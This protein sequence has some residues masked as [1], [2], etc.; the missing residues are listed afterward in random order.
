MTGVQTCALPISTGGD[1][2]AYAYHCMPRGVPE[3]MQ[4]VTRSY[5]FVLTPGLIAIIPQNNE[6]RWVYMDGRKMPADWKK[7]YNGFSIGHWEGEMLVVE[8][9]GIRPNTD[10]FYG[11]PGGT[12]QHVLE[13][14]KRIGNET[15]QYDTTIEDPTALASPY[16]FRR[17]FTRSPTPISD[18][19]CLQNNRDVGPDG[20]QQ[21]DL[22]P[23]PGLD[24]KPKP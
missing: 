14:F 18:E 23:P 12:Q 11:F 9:I 2:P 4:V 13:R 8:T 7:S 3:I 1:V 6:L 16:T 17:T 21:F 19:S 24:W 10:M 15:L 20:K 22:T 5:E